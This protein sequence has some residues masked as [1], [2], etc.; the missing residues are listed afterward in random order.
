VFARRRPCGKAA[1]RAASG[2]E[3]CPAQ[4]GEGVPVRTHT[5][6]P[7]QEP[8]WNG[9]R[10]FGLKL[11]HVLKL[12]LPRLD[13]SSV[14]V[15]EGKAATLARRVGGQE[16]GSRPRA[17]HSPAR[18]GLAGSVRG[19]TRQPEEGQEGAMAMAPSVPSCWGRRLGTS[20]AA[21]LGCSPRGLAVL[22]G[23]GGE[24]SPLTELT[25]RHAAG[26]SLP[27]LAAGH[28]DEWDTR[29]QRSAGNVLCRW[30]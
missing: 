15:L 25:Q 2:D 13:S 29:K 19:R 17:R 8:W 20:P 14:T 21:C 5:R 28:E 6:L 23:S 22:H 27:F 11:A 12:P 1:H 24:N 9:G 10:A 30:D 3:L 18:C 7:G 16:P 26:C 4:E